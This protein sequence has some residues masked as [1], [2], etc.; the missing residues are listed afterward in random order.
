MSRGTGEGPGDLLA[1][2][3]PYRSRLRGPHQHNGPHVD[4][5]R[6][7]VGQPHDPDPG[8]LEELR[9]VYLEAEGDLEGGE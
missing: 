8:V 3:P 7:Q 2:T 1:G 4:L 5:G 9:R 6:I